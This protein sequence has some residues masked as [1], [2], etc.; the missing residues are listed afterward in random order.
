MFECSNIQ[1]LIN[2]P[3]MQCT[4]EGKSAS[5]CSGSCPVFPSSIFFITQNPRHSEDTLNMLQQLV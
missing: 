2:L 5:H 4:I 1:M 3:A